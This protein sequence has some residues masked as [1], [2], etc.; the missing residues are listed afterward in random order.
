MK[1]YYLSK[2]NDKKHKFQILTPQGKK[3]KIRCLW[4]FSKR[5]LA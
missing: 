3:N 1:I 5:T 4:I 2:A